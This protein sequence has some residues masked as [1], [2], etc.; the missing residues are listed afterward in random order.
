MARRLIMVSAAL[1]LL[2]TGASAQPD[3]PDLRGRWIITTTT[4]GHL[5]ATEHE[6]SEPFLGS[7]NM[8]VEIVFQDGVRFA[9]VEMEQDISTELG[10]MDEEVFSG[11]FGYDERT[12]YTVD[13]NG[14]S[15]CPN[16]TADRMECIYRHITPQSSV[17]AWTL[18]VRND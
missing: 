12:A 10:P 18:W 9:G 6:P 13:H 5:N 17:A 11:I 8:H 1:C 14:F 7:F 15:T 2:A 3:V 16:V 4:I